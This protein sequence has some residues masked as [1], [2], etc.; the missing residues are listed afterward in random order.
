MSNLLS[1]TIEILA[2]NG[3]SPNDVLWVQANDGVGTW[4]N[5]SALA[6]FEY[7]PG[8]GGA[9]VA[10]DLKIVGNDWWLERGE[11]G[12]SE[13]WEFKT[14]PAQPGQAPPLSCITE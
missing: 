4:D 8:Y 5:F 12:G 3:K 6:D 10:M 9:E 7:D 13:W 11:Y 1:E 2:A 14:L